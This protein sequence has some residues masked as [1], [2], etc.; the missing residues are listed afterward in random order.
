MVIDNYTFNYNKDGES[1][2]RPARYTF[3]Y[4]KRNGQW[5]IV[6][7]HSSAMPAPTK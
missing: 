4:A 1:K 3:V 7:H 2:S 5:M 6:D